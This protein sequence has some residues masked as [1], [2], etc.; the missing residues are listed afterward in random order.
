MVV[1]HHHAVENGG[2]RV[3]VSHV[4]LLRCFGSVWG[5]GR[6]VAGSSPP[7]S[8]GQ[9]KHRALGSPGRRTRSPQGRGWAGTNFSNRL[10]SDQSDPCKKFKGTTRWPPAAI[11]HRKESAMS[12]RIGPSL[13][14]VAALVALALGL[15][16]YFAPLTG[17][18][19]VWGPLAAAFGA[20]CL[21]IGGRQLLVST[22]PRPTRG[23]NQSCW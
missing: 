9:R 20:L 6:F 17:V 22:L 18:T 2:F 12:H 4:W 5:A 13:V 14:I 8:M 15:Y 19:G 21:A 10:P 7:G 1:G 16:A 11:N 23:E 3:V